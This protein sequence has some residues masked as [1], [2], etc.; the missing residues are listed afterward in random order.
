MEDI[1]VYFINDEAYIAAESKIDAIQFYEKEYAEVQKIEKADL[2]EMFWDCNIPEDIR[3]DLYDQILDADGTS[4][5]GQVWNQN[6]RGELKEGSIK[7]ISGDYY[8]YKSFKTAISEIEKF[9][10]KLA[11]REE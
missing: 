3:N 11:G 9:P 7:M 8:I 4:Q 6:I 5:N 10:C 2:N 1:K